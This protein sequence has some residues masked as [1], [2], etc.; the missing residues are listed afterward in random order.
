VYLEL[1]PELSVLGSP[2]QLRQVF[3]NLVLNAAEA[4]GADNEIR[5]RGAY[6]AAEEADG[7]PMVEVEISDQGE[8]IPAEILERVFEPF[9][10][11]KPKGTGLGLA[12]V[13]RV[14]EAHGGQLVLKSRSGE[15]TSVRVR[16]PAAPL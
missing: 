6:V 5:V 10:T 16:L 7:S 1:P 15:G 9:F 8:G 14:V 3:W 12:T 4:G 13:H 11:T 2:D